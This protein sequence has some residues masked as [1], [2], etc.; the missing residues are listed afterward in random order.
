MAFDARSTIMVSWC[1]LILGYMY[2]VGKYFPRTKL[3][4]FKML[5]KVEFHI[6]ITY[7][8]NELSLSP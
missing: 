7:I 4:K 2:I 3:L 1:E 8:L 5:K 6:N